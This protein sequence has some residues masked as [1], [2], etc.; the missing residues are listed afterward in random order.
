M[1]AA[2]A[3][4]AAAAATLEGGLEFQRWCATLTYCCVMRGPGNVVTWVILTGMGGSDIIEG[5]LLANCVR[6]SGDHG[7][8]AAVVASD[9]QN[10]SRSSIIIYLYL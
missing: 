1:T 7:T 3:A 6:E 4:A 9:A 2:A 5:N 10:L 8:Y